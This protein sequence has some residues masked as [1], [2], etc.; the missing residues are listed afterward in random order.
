VRPLDLGAQ[1][2]HLA[3]HGALGRGLG[4]RVMISSMSNGLVMSS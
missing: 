2:A 4:A 3:L 1:V